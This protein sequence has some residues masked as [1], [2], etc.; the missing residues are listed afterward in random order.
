MLD[1]SAVEKVL[2]KAFAAFKNKDYTTALEHLQAAL[3]Q[4]T[5]PARQAKIRENVADVHNARGV[6]VIDRRTPPSTSSAAR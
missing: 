3:A 6:D 2:D 5:D 1:K 4:T